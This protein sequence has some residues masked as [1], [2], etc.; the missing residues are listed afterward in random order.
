MGTSQKETRPPEPPGPANAPERPPSRIRRI[1]RRSPASTLPPQ[2]SLRWSFTWAFEGIVYVLRTQRNMQIHVA[3]AVVALVLGL[4]LDFSRLE[5]VVR[6]FTGSH[7]L[8]VS[9]KGTIRNK[10][11]YNRTQY[12]RLTEVDPETFANMIDLWVLEYAE[13]YATK[14]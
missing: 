4:L 7:V 5:L 11:V 6:P 9:A 13:L 2:G 12:Q 14:V 3:A 8:E 10:E 1:L